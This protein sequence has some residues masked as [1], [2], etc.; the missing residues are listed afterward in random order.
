MRR[1]R[2]PEQWPRTYPS[3][4]QLR[5]IR[6][7]WGAARSCRE[8]GRRA[9]SVA[10]CVGCPLPP[11]P[12]PP[13]DLWAAA[14]STRRV[15]ALEQGKRHNM[16]FGDRGGEQG[17]SEEAA[18]SPVRV[19]GESL[20]IAARA[21]GMAAS[22]MLPPLA[23]S[24][25]KRRRGPPIGARVVKATRRGGGRAPPM[26]GCVGA[27]CRG[28]GP[29]RRTARRVTDSDDGAPAS[30]PRKKIL[31]SKCFCVFVCFGTLPTLPRVR[32]PR[33]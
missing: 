12:P 6:A 25:A 17:A 2:G 23:S 22:E 28:L 18:M 24:S 19:T 31:F 20:A 16:D 33:V 9:Q 29:R 26:H 4:L 21:Y 32:H 3:V 5:R 1:G 11:H 14:R 15:R 10:S 30:L 7:P 8:P 27:G 13:L